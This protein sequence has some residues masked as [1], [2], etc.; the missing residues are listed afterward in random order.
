VRKEWPR[1]LPLLAK[2][3]D[4]I[5]QSLAQKDLAN[6]STVAAQLEVADGW[7]DQAEKQRDPAAK[8]RVASRART[9]YEQALAGAAGL[10]KAKVEKRLEEIDHLHASGAVVD[11]LPLID[12]KKDGYQGGW[13]KS[14]GS[15]LSPVPVAQASLQI[16]YMPPAEYDLKMVIEKKDIHVLHVGLPSDNVRIGVDVDNQST[17]GTLNFPAPSGKNS[18]VKYNGS[19]TS[20]GKPSTLLISVRKMGVWVSI[21]NKVVLS[22]EGDI[23]AAGPDSSWNPP[24]A[25]C[26]ML[27]SWGGWIISKMVLIPVSG[28]GKPLR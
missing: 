16:P 11:L 26:L 7:W 25:K 18:I 14:G 20:K 17:W 10:Q 27:G 13:D 15:L 19:Y 12:P 3:N 23:S 8:R 9:W 5:L 28:Q 21:D 4:A 22:Y 24:N 6:P 2:G 1:G